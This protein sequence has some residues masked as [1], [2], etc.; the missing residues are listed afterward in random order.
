MDKFKR[1]KGDFGGVSRDR[2]VLKK[3]RR[4]LRVV[5]Q[6]SYWGTEGKNTDHEERCARIE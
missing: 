4:G 6:W 3:A 5:I 2:S 1:N